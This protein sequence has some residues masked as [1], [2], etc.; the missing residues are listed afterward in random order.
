MAKKPKTPD[1]PSMEGEGVSQKKIPA[2]EKAAGNYVEVRDSRMKLTKEEVAARAVLINALNENGVTRYQYDDNI[3][4]LKP[5]EAKV[6]VRLVD[7]DD[8]EEG[9]DDED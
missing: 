4:E 9:E 2:I 7:P 8:A 5:G 3:V 1:L 6:K